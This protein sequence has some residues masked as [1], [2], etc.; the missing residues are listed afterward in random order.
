M[1]TW[2]RTAVARHLIAD[3]PNPGYSRLDRMDGL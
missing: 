2:F 1:R 3:D